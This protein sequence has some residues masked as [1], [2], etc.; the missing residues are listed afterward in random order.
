MQVVEYRWPYGHP[1]SF[2][3]FGHVFDDLNT[4]YA[5]LA[6]LTGI[7]LDNTFTGT[8]TLISRAWDPFFPIQNHHVF[9]S[10]MILDHPLY[11]QI[12][13]GDRLACHD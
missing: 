6:G 11:V 9:S 8:L 1:I 7:D 2:H 12:C 10:G 4:T 5:S 13:K 3:S